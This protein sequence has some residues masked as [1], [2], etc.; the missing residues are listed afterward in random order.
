MKNKIKGTLVILTLNEIDGLKKIYP[1]IP[2]NEIGEI[3]AIDGG[4]T[5]GTLEFYQKNKVRVMKQK[6][7]GRGEAFR[8]A[9]KKAKYNNLVFFSPDGNENPK[10]IP[11]IFSYLEKSYDIVIASRFMKGA[12]CDEDHKL[13]KIRKFGNKIFTLIINILFGGQLTDSINGF[14]VTGM[15]TA[16]NN[17]TVLISKGTCLSTDKA[18]LL[19]SFK[20]NG[21]TGGD[22]TKWL[23]KASSTSFVKVVLY[24]P[25]GEP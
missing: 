11:K 10:D 5:D 14:R 8:I 7:R 21:W 15:S 13:I 12:K 25:S 19:D 16:L 3:F 1:S 18:Y 22:L 2:I 4:S 24:I 17:V 9:L 6:S 20:D 23:I